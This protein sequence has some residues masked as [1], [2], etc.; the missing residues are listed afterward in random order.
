VSPDRLLPPFY[1]FANTAL[2][3]LLFPLTRVQVTMRG[4]ENVPREGAFILVS[5]HL[6][7]L[8]PPLLGTYIP[9]DLEMMSKAENFEGGR[10]M[11]WVV[12]NYGAFPIRRGQGD[13]GAIRHAMKV[14]KEGRAL[15]VAPEGTRSMTGQLGEP[16]EG[17]VLLALRSGVPI[18][19]V[20]ISGV[21]HFA[22]RV[23]RWRPTPVLLSVGQ[24][25]RL[26]SPTPRP[27]RRTLEALSEAVMARIAA[28]LP[29]PYRG[30]FERVESALLTSG[31]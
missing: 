31:C 30:R 8:D 17:V 7:L 10:L 9:R 20:G 23:K 5:N 4:K 3:Y 24:P 22:Q 21:E 6:S 25:F 14:L 12:S 2:R 29:P 1:Y 27:D 15:Y 19:P 16:H 26:Q 18:V 13:V 28:E 11:R